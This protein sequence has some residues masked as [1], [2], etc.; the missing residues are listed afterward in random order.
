MV[1]VKDGAMDGA[2]E[3]I[4]VAPLFCSDDGDG[5]QL[6]VVVVQRSRRSVGR[7]NDEKKYRT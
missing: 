5:A 7:C 4:V 3:E 1:A 2:M 6:L